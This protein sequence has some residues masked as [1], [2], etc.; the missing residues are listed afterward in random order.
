MKALK[1]FGVVAGILIISL[2]LILLV[3]ISLLNNRCKK[4]IALLHAQGK[5]V[6]MHDLLKNRIPDSENAAVVY[7]Q[8]FQKMAEP[9]R[10]NDLDLIADSN[11]LKTPS[12]LSNLGDLHKAL[13]RNQDLFRLVEK[14]VSRPQCQFNLINKSNGSMDFSSFKCIRD[15]SRILCNKAVCEAH[16]GE[17]DKAFQSMHLATKF[18]NCLKDAPTLIGFLVRDSQLAITSRAL[19][20]TMNL[21]CYTEPQAY[22]LFN[23][24]SQIENMK[25]YI[26]AMESE[27]AYIISEL[28]GIHGKIFQVYT[29]ASYLDEMQKQL[30]TAKLSYREARLQNKLSNG[31]NIS[32]YNPFIK[33]SSSAYAKTTANRDSVMAQMNGIRIV[34]AVKTYKSRSGSY[35]ASLNDVKTKLKW[36]LPIDPFSGKDFIYKHDGKGFVVYSIGQNLKDDGGLDPYDPKNHITPVE[37][38]VVW[39]MDH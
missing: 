13:N 36:K 27:R 25:S 38:D 31:L 21:G 2:A 10:K 12:N 17:M 30:D 29:K 15:L 37:G 5:P 7:T 4:S 34:L 8:I 32:S 6:N 19:F 28:D 18:S 1:T 26:H 24:I 14:A 23:E 35:P 20:Q 33:A 39:R 16:D 9:S 11:A 22:E 3:S